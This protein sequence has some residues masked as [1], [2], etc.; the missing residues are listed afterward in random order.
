[1]ATELKRRARECIEQLA[2]LDE[3]KK[4][5]SGVHGQAIGCEPWVI[6]TNGRNLSCL[7]EAQMLLDEV[8]DPFD[9]RATPPSTS[10]NPLHKCEKCERTS[11]IVKLDEHCP[12]CAPSTAREAELP[13]LPER[14]G[15]WAGDDWYTADSMRDYARAALAASNPAPAGAAKGRE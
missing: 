11:E 8:L 4:P 6:R 15:D 2:A 13:P 1:M 7:V 14:D 3:S 5:G 9:R 10:T 12:F